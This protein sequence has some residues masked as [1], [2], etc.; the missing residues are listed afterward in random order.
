M[1]KKALTPELK[2]I[3]E[4]VM[5]TPTR[6]PMQQ[7]ISQTVSV[8]AQGVPPLGS[9]VGNFVPPTPPAPTPVTS[10]SSVTPQAIK[11]TSNTAFVFSN[12]NNGAADEPHTITATRAGNSKALPV[13]IGFLVVIFVATYTFIWMVVFDLIKLPF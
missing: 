2:Q 5:S 8:Q 13:F 6:P 3:Y 1:D 11:N 9:P 10:F 4:K 7:P 12:K